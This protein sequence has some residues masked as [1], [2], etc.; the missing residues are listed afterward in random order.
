MSDLGYSFWEKDAFSLSLGLSDPASSSQDLHSDRSIAQEENRAAE[1]HF[2]ARTWSTPFSQRHS[3]AC[4]DFLASSTSGC[5][6]NIFIMDS[7][8]D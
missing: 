4:T 2:K 1:P 6:F 8:L 7:M 3:L 5:M